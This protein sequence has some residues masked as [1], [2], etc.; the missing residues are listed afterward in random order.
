MSLH[1]AERSMPESND[2]PE[3]PQSAPTDDP[4]GQDLDSRE[5][6]ELLYGHL[7]AIAGRKLADFNGPAS[8]RPTELV[9]EAYMKVDGKAFDSRS[10]F[11]SVCATAMRHVLVD[12]A[13]RRLAGK[14]GSGDRPATLIEEISSSERSWTTLLEVSEA[15]DRLGDID[16]RLVKLVDCK[17]YAGLTFQE[18]ADAMSISERT[19]RRD[20]QRAKAWLQR[21]LAAAG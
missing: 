7:R 19:A 16:P 5:L 12:A 20:W 15:L 2:T 3:R 17:V 8:I 1:F 13:R 18:T 21:S 4:A 6:L 9:H 11:L 14:R 10:H